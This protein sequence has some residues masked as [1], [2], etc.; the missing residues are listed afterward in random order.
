MRPSLDNQT[1]DRTSSYSGRMDS[2]ITANEY[3][4]REIA[5]FGEDEIYDLIDK[6]YVPV[7]SD[8]GWKWLPSE[9]SVDTDAGFCYATSADT[10]SYSRSAGLSVIGA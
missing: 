8:R 6:G 5:I 7:M 10:P 9:T 4:K 3:V 2:M 1:L